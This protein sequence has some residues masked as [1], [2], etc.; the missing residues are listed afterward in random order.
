MTERPIRPR[1]HSALATA[2]IELRLHRAN[3]EARLAESR[4]LREEARALRAE[5]RVTQHRARVRR[6]DPGE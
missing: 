2:R 6:G 3:M 5:A 4:E 1:V